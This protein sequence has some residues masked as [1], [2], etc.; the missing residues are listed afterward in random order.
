MTCSQISA[1][2]LVCSQ[3]KDGEIVELQRQLAAS[4]GDVRRLQ[5]RLRQAEADQL[6]NVPSA[7]R[8]SRS[9]FYTW[10]D[11]AEQRQ[12]ALRRLRELIIAPAIRMIDEAQRAAVF[13]VAR[14]RDALV[15]SLVQARIVMRQVRTLLEDYTAT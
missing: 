4:Q 13:Q 11:V 5:E 10:Q 14:T 2:N 7:N 9:G 1:L 3:F 12:V 6:S 8:F 15:A